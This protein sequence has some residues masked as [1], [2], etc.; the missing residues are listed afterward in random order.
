MF[1]G[2][3]GD[4]EVEQMKSICN[5]VHEWTIQCAVDYLAEINPT[6]GKKNKH[7]I[8]KEINIPGAKVTQQYKLGSWKQANMLILSHRD[9]Q[10]VS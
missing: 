5:N 2:W 4:T 1:R 8:H 6:K 3:K 9:T 10:K 7:A